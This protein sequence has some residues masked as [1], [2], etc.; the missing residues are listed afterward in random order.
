[1]KNVWLKLCAVILILAGLFLAFHRYDAHNPLTQPLLNPYVI[2]KKSKRQLMLYS[3]NKLLRTYTV[4]SGFNPVADKAKEG[5]GATPE[6][7]FYIFTKNEQS[8]YYLSLGISYPNVEDAQRGLRDSLINEEQYNEIVDAIQSRGAPLQHTPLGGEIYIHGR[9]SQKDW[10]WGCVALDDDNMKE[11]F[12]A[13]PVGA[14]SLHGEWTFGS[15][16]QVRITGHATVD[17]FA[18][19]LLEKLL[20]I[21]ILERLAPTKTRW[22]GQPREMNEPCL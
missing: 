20:D 14:R 3:D 13:V 5:D 7:E 9:G 8:A 18:L 10:T 6:G 2:I 12:E 11:F 17:C 22:L 1:M 19:A 4:G 16:T 15:R 21:E